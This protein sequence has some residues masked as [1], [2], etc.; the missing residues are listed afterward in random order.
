M[1]PRK[2]ITASSTNRRSCSGGIAQ[3]GK[4]SSKSANSG[5]RRANQAQ[6]CS[7]ARRRAGSCSR[8]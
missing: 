8:A 5:S 1:A 7:V 2:R 3:A 4:G 6:P